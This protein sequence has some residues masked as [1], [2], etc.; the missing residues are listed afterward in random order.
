MIPLSLEAFLSRT[1]AIC[2]FLLCG[3]MKL[4]HIT[5]KVDYVRQYF[6]CD[7]ICSVHNV[8]KAV[9]TVDFRSLLTERGHLLF[10]GAW[11]TLLQSAGLEAGDIPERLNLI[12]PEKV[13]AVAQSYVDAGSDMII[14][15]SFGGS[16][17][18]LSN[19]GLED[20]VKE[21]NI[22][23]ARISKRIAGNERLVFGSVGPTGRFVE[24][25]GD[26]SVEE[27]T[28]IFVEQIEALVSGGVDGILIETMVDLQE[29][30]CAITAAKSVFDGP[31]ACT[32]A[33]DYLPAGFRT[34][35]G[36][37]PEQFVDRITRAG[38]DIIGANCGSVNPIQMV[39]LVARLR[40]LTDLPI[41][42][43]P[44][45]GLPRLIDGVTVFQE[46]PEVFSRIA[47]RLIDAGASIIGGCCGTTPDHIRAMKS[48]LTRKN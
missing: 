4:L 19:Y 35:M 38:A 24:P 28:N 17:L 10:D 8:A 7:I 33:F 43:R 48:A 27:M 46:S 34:M 25:I 1:V 2:V 42:A 16:R 6:S 3:H 47:V 23:A 37:S 26:V 21:I 14:T 36:V 18:K 44:N 9:S 20:S 22:E 13:A 30:E 32:F 5:V 41:V 40:S 31:I 29:A 11:G 39:D 45:G 12:A 15:N